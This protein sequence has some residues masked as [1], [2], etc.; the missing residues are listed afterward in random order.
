MNLPT[1]NQPYPGRWKMLNLSWVAFFL[2]FVVW[3]N[4]GAFSTTI[5]RVLHLTKEQSQVLLLC[6]LALTIPARIALGHCDQRPA[7]CRVGGRVLPQG[8]R[9]P[10]GQGIQE[11]EKT[12]RA[13]S[14][15]A[16]GSAGA[17]LH[18]DPDDP[19]PRRH[20]LASGPREVFARHRVL[21][22]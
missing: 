8:G 4:L 13:R 5:A 14:H 12:R 20:R 10:A 3:Y 22:H 17:V 18:A 6:N 16:P 21:R 11:A 7:V 15:F 9:C 1:E 19:L 2:T